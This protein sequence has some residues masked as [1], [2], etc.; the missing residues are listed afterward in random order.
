[1]FSFLHVLEILNGVKNSIVI[2]KLFLSSRNLDIENIIKLLKATI[3]AKTTVRLD[4]CPHLIDLTNGLFCFKRQTSI[5]AEQLSSLQCCFDDVIIKQLTLKKCRFVDDAIICLC[6]L[7]EKNN[8]L[9]SLDLSE[10][11]LTDE[12]IRRISLTL[13]S[14]SSL[15]RINFSNNFSNFRTL[16]NTFVFIQISPHFID[17]NIGHICYENEIVTTDLCLLLKDLKAFKVPIKRIQCRGLKSPNLEG[18][19]ALF[20]ILS[21]NSGILDL[22]ISPHSVDVENAIFCFSPKDSTPITEASL[23]SLSH[24]F[25]IRE[26]SL[27]R[28]RFSDLALTLLKEFVRFNHNLTSVD[29]SD[30]HLSTEQLCELCNP[31]LVGSSITNINISH[32]SI[33]F[34]FLVSILELNSRGKLVPHFQVSPHSL[35]ASTIVYE[36]EMENEDIIYLLNALKLNVPIK[37]VDTCQ[38]F[39]NPA[40]EGLNHLFEVLSIN[41]SIIVLDISPHSIDV[42]NNV[43]CFVPQN[44]T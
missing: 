2:Q 25:V 33:T 32:K 19:I 1:M 17:T 42:E 20:E 27:N 16:L 35:D 36:N 10:C 26:L 30:C 5:T 22:D 38:G 11:Q 23:Q 44:A 31:M 41:T 24:T 28:C 18:V 15:R 7:L 34:E 21:I 12:N 39:R 6:K 9:T 8:S 29:L 14:K 37:R 4:V 13:I 43:I 40:F 3:S